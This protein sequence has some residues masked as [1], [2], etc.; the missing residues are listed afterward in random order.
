MSDRAPNGDHSSD[1]ATTKRDST[2]P[3]KRR[4]LSAEQTRARLIEAGLDQLMAE[5]LPPRIDH[6]SLERLAQLADLPRSSA[7]NAWQDRTD[8]GRTPQSVF[9]RELIRQLI[10]DEGDGRRDSAPMIGV[11]RDLNEVFAALAPEDRQRE[12]VRRATAAQFE[13][14]F[15]RHGFRAA[16]ALAAATTSVPGGELDSEILSW[17]R[18][19]EANYVQE[20]VGLFK[21]MADFLEL[22]PSPEFAQVNF[23]EIFATVILAVGEG[24]FPRVLTS[25]PDWIL[26]VDGPGPNGTRRPWT[27]YAIAIDALIDKF[28]VRRS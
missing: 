8:Q 25:D 22:E 20:L 11:G 23:H 16:M 3:V 27:L 10:L 15:E 13:A 2:V 28:F 1:D 9:Q 12:L 21:G 14:S 19:A 6:V 7:Y 18:A 17:L 24:L 4:R 26:K 5:G